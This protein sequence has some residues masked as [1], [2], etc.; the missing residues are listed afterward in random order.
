MT[1]P[2]TLRSRTLGALLGVHA[3][4]ALGATLEFLPWETIRAHHPNHTSITGGGPFSFPPGHATDD[5]D[6]TRAVLLAYRTS[7]P[8]TTPLTLTYGAAQHF[9]AWFTGFWPDRVAGERPADVGGAT[10][11]GI[12]TFQRTG[13]A[14]TS[15]AGEG[16]AGNGSLMRC[17]ATGLFQGEWERMVVE[18]DLISA[19]THDDPHCTLACA[20]YNGI[21]RGL[22]EG[23][24]VREAIELGIKAVGDAR[25]LPTHGERRTPESMLELAVKR[26]EGAIVAGRDLVTVRELAEEGPR[27]ARNGRKVLPFKGAGYVLESLTIAVAA[28]VDERGLEEV[29]VDVVRIGKDTDTNGAIAGGLLGARDGVEGIPGTWREKLQFAAEFEEIV[30]EM[31]SR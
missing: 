31:L 7:S 24:G 12:R 9:V 14:T 18:S 4:D 29:L 6:L 15:G 17:I 19:V 2:P 30:D 3:G 21:V 5:T 25:K 28:L 13:D 8:T 10:A 1:T 16:S 22:V 26:V 23:R 20:G 11:K 27:E